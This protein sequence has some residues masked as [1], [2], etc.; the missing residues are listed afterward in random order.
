MR[1]GDFGL[2][3]LFWRV[4][5]SIS[6]RL[7]ISLR[8]VNAQANVVY[9]RDAEPGSGLRPV[10]G[11]ARGEIVQDDIGFFIPPNAAP[12]QYRLVIVVYN[13]AS[14]EE[15]VAPDIAATSIQMIDVTK[16]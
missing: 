16:P 3:T 14:G 2:V 9:Q 15:L 8:V 7:T 1:P 12:G 11:W 4:P 13:P 6:M 5:Q 10:I